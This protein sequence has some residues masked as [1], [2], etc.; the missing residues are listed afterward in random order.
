VV[1]FLGRRPVPNPQQPNPEDTITVFN[2]WPF[3]A[4]LLNSQLLAER[5][6]FNN[7]ALF[8][9]E[10]ELKQLQHKPDKDFQD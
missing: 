5:K 2:L 3:D 6:V 8:A 4:A 10:Y 1:Q 9:P 7:D